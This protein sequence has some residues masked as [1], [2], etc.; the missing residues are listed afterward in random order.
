MNTTYTYIHGIHVSYYSPAV[1]V[2]T[3]N[4]I[5]PPQSVRGEGGRAGEM[6][7]ERERERETVRAGKTGPSA[8]LIKY[9]THWHAHTGTQ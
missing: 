2:H 1:Y 5:T 6:E 7:R 4:V 3:F 9:Y 8:A